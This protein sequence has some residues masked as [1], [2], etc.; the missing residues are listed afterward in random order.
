M[1]LSCKIGIM[2]KYQSI[3]KIKAVAAVTTATA[4]GKRFKMPI[5]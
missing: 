2:G 4:M 5:I 3:I 1:F